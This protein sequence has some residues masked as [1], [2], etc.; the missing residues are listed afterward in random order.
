MSHPALISV[1]WGTSTL[2]AA[3]LAPDGTIIAHSEEGPGI[4]PNPAGGFEPVLTQLTA[5]WRNDY[6]PL[7]VIMSG[8]IGSR[9]GWHEVPYLACPATVSELAAH[10]HIVFSAA[11]G[12]LHFV[13]GLVFAPSGQPPEVMR[14]EETQIMGALAA[15][16]TLPGASARVFVLPGT[17]SKWAWTADGAI[18]KF[19][20]YMTGEIFA[21]LRNHSILGRLMP[22]G[23]SPFDEPAFELGVTAGAA[24]GPPGALLNRV[25]DQRLSGA[26]ERS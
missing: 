8:M 19:V 6:G 10:L 1:D 4:Q 13:P 24:D 11:I 25:V 14:G 20:T 2:R 7:P 3:L 12:N 22:D 17:H 15:D 9:Q 5:T 16:R 26:A 21:V 23:P 18:V